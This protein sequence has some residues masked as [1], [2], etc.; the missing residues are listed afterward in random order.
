MPGVRKGTGKG[1]EVRGPG[2]GPGSH[3][4]RTDAKGKIPEK[5]QVVVGGMVRG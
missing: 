3:E 1:V 2:E 4:L 5:S